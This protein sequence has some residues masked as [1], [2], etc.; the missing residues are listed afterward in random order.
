MT[1]DLI[2][3]QDAF[4]QVGKA[5]FGRRWIGALNERDEHVAKVAANGPPFL[6]DTAEVEKRADWMAY[7]H[8]AVQTWLRRHGFR[9]EQKLP[10]REFK[11]L[12]AEA[13]SPFGGGMAS[14]GFHLTE[15][16]ARVG[17]SKFNE[18]WIDSLTDNECRIRDGWPSTAAEFVAVDSKVRK[19]CQQH[20][21]VWR[22]LDNHY[23]DEATR[24][25]DGTEFER[26]FAE[27]F[28]SR[29]QDERSPVLEAD[30][31][32][33][34]RGDGA[35]S[36]KQADQSARFNQKR[37]AAPKR[38]VVEK[39]VKAHRYHIDPKGKSYKQMATELEGEIGTVFGANPEARARAVARV[40][41]DFRRRKKS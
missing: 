25:D 16:F 37:K 5:K 13:D 41:R 15:A 4:E 12:F 3:W 20:R 31:G 10:R 33:L 1:N 23:F 7:Q 19:M 22:W 40:V 32:V 17:K 18:D 11:K 8:R 21:W 28:A 30:Q 2:V 35:V 9:P 24:E 34:R 6:S 26:A 38:D 39:A 36:K 27:E 14:D 29:E